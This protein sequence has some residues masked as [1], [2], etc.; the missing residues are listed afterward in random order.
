MGK[1][2]L[3]TKPEVRTEFGDPAGG[4]Y[5][6]DVLI[7][8]LF[9][10][11][12]SLCLVFLSP[13]LFYFIF[14]WRAELNVGISPTAPKQCEYSSH[15]FLCLSA[16]SQKKGFKPQSNTK[17]VFRFSC[18]ALRLETFLLRRRTKT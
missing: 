18:Q 2:E 14:N 17:T 16:H 3:T 5:D 6:T 4:C 12:L 9:T 13:F 8:Y 1:K 7:D 10:L 15:V 11:F